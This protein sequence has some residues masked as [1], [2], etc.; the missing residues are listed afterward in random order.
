VIG[1]D[2]GEDLMRAVKHRSD[3]R[4]PEPSRHKVKNVHYQLNQMRD[5]VIP[6]S[7]SLGFAKTVSSQLSSAGCI[8]FS[9]IV[10]SKS[11]KAVLAQELVKEESKQ[12]VQFLDV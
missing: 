10:H 11:I 9:A 1:C 8:I 2:P 12:C 4:I 3:N 6:P 7:C 5:V